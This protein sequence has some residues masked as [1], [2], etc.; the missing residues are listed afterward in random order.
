MRK[1]MAAVKILE[2]ANGLK[3]GAF[4]FPDRK[5]PC[6][7][8]QRGNEVVVYGTFQSAEAAD[9]FMTELAKLIGAIKEGV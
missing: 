9:L 1:E 6:L 4:L 3:I 2:G 5:R 8:V 7:C